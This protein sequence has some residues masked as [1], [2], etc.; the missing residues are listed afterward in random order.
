LDN[1]DIASR[2]IQLLLGSANEKKV[3]DFLLHA[4]TS[5]RQGLFSMRR[6]ESST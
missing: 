1:K 2:I 3:E 5:C 6:G 4:E